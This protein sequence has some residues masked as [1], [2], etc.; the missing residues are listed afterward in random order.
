MTKYSPLT[1][2]MSNEVR[3]SQRKFIAIVII[4]VILLIYTLTRSSSCDSKEFTINNNQQQSQSLDNKP[5]IYAITPTYA[6]PV[7]KAE[8]TRLSHVFRLVPNLFWVIVEDADETSALVRNLVNRAMLSQRCV[9][10]N[11]KTPTNFKLSKRD[12]HWSKPR[13]VEQRNEALKWIRKKIKHEPGHS[14]VYFMDDDNSYSTELFEEMSKIERMRVG[15]WPVGLVG[16]MKVEKPIVENDKVVGFNSVWRPERPF[17]I[18]MAGFAISSD[19]FE[20]NPS[21]QF[22]YEVEKGY[23]ESEILRQVTTREKLQPIASNQILVWHTRT[24]ASK[25]DNEIKLGKKGL[26][27][28]DEGMII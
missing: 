5:I 20:A 14:I 9:L 10:L 2:K 6:R 21:A 25:M 4:V 27:P 16:A 13:G 28:S 18:D 7:Q 19:L 12:P 3:I 15:V 23:Q 11:A 8:L 26:P 24:E 17:P 1:R 22:N